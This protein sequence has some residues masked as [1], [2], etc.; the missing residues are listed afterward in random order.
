MIYFIEPIYLFI[1]KEVET[2]K[3]FILQKLVQGILQVH[4]NDLKFNILKTKSLFMAF[5][6]KDTL[7]I[8]GT[9]IYLAL[10]ILIKYSFF[11]LKK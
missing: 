10:H 5:T 2:K 8:G 6:K 7:N 1:I 9:T 3:T 11:N 4:Y